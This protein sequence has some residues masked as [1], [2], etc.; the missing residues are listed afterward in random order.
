MAAYIFPTVL[1]DILFSYDYFLEH[2]TAKTI[3]IPTICL[4]LLIR[5]L[6]E[7]QMII[8][9]KIEMCHRHFFN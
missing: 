9:K 7:S 8:G 6:A 1:Y 2:L 3:I 5:K 4:W